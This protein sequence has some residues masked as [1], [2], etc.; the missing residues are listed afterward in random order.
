[1]KRCYHREVAEFQWSK[2]KNWWRRRE[3]NSDPKANA[4]GLYM[5]SHF[6]FLPGKPSKILLVA[7]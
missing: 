4:E 1:M 2:L 5:L 3:L 6:S 7:E